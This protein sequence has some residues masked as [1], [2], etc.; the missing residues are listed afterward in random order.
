MEEFKEAINTFNQGKAKEAM[1][2][3]A[4]EIKKLHQHARKEKKRKRRS[5]KTKSEQ[6]DE[7]VSYA[8]PDGPMSPHSSMWVLKSPSHLPTSPNSLIDFRKKKLSFSQ[9]KFSTLDFTDD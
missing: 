6:V 4:N 5:E 7:K 8:L 2:N 9:R 3:V 1:R